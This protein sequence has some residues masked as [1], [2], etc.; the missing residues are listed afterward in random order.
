MGLSVSASAGVVLVGVILIFGTLQ[1]AVEKASEIKEEARSDWLDWKEKK[2]KS[3]MEI[4]EINYTESKSIL[5][6]TVKNNGDA[7][8]DIREI[9]VLLNGTYST[10]KIN[11]TV[12]DNHIKNTNV[13]NPGQV[14]NI[15]LE[16]VKQKISRIV[17]VNE[18]GSKTYYVMG[19]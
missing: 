12:V 13:L 6:I 1:P 16:E 2:E 8:L 19:A 7:P 3:E 11:S 14:L 10:H 5:N 4:L 9:E 17:V 15:T 18:F